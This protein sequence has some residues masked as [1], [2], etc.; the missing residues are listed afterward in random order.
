MFNNLHDLWY[1]H[2]QHTFLHFHCR[3]LAFGRQ[4]RS[5][6][7]RLQSRTVFS[8]DCQN[9]CGTR[10]GLLRPCRHEESKVLLRMVVHALRPRQ[11]CRVHNRAGIC[12]E[13]MKMIFHNTPQSVPASSFNPDTAK[14]ELLEIASL[15]SNTVAVSRFSSTDPLCWP[16]IRS[17]IATQT[18]QLQIDSQAPSAEHR[19]YVLVLRD[20]FVGLP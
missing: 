3:F 9:R 19:R 13:V 12:C 6:G 15:S 7:G 17:V 2:W 18:Q 16:T 1:A 4:T 14:S 11:H 8:R 10:R 5:R 20:A